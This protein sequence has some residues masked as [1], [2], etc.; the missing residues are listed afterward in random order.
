MSFTEMD[1]N[2]QSKSGKTFPVAG[3]PGYGATAFQ[4]AVADA[5]R[6]E[7]GGSP[8]AVKRIAILVAA[9]ERAVKNWFAARNGPTGE[10]LVLLMHHSVA[11]LEAVLG[12]SGQT[13]LLRVRLF[14][15]VRDHLRQSLQ[16]LDDLVIG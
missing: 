7:F 9:N 13:A 11:V 5:L 15:D 8:A 16:M 10:H 1:R 3:A 2:F 12:L 6:R 14:S 4:E